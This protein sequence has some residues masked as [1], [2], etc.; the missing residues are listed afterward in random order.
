MLIWVRIVSKGYVAEH[1]R[2]P[3]MLPTSSSSKLFSSLPFS[4]VRVCR[5]AGDGHIQGIIH[6]NYGIQDQCGSEGAEVYQWLRTRIE[7]TSLNEW[8]AANW[9]AVC[10]KILAR[11]AAFPDQSPTNPPSLHIDTNDLR[12]P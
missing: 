3:A 2:S 1:A 5:E 11:V 4:P 6:H 7:S 12:N 10:G 9:I 8:N